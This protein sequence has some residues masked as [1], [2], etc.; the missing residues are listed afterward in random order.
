MAG[1]GRRRTRSQNYTTLQPES[2]RAREA[3]MFYAPTRGAGDGPGASAADATER[4]L[5]EYVRTQ[6]RTARTVQ[7]AEAAD[8]ILHPASDGGDS[9]SAETMQAASE[10]LKGVAESARADARDAREAAAAA[11][12][13][14]DS[15]RKDGADSVATAYAASRDADRSVATAAMQMVKEVTSATVEATKVSAAA[16]VEAARQGAQAQVEAANA[17]S[18]FF[19][20]LA[21]TLIGRQQQA[22]Q[23]QGTDLFG[24]MEQLAKLRA[25]M[26]AQQQGE[27]AAEYERR[28]MTDARVEAWKAQNASNAKA[29][30]GFIGFLNGNLGPL[31]QALGG[32]VQQ[33]VGG[34]AAGLGPLPGGPA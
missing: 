3:A 25:L 17:R 23:Q 7:A 30:E 31:I 29:V 9:V 4:E 6:L 19:E 12:A 16:Q 21:T 5:G 28:V 22:Q 27:S 1:K 14:L 13:R 18:Q 34:A 8:R 26:P 2:E 24:A 10:V 15:A 33:K 32:L 20:N 11:Q